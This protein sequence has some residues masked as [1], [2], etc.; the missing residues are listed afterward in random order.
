[1]LDYHS[2]KVFNTMVEWD[3]VEVFGT[4]V[5]WNREPYKTKLIMA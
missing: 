2:V 3:R 1:M 4:Y 5:V